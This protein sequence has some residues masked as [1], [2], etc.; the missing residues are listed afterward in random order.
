MLTKEGVFG[1]YECLRK[2]EPYRCGFFASA[3]SPSMLLAAGG[4]CKGCAFRHQPIRLILLW[5]GGKEEP[6]RAETR[7]RSEKMDAITM[8][9]IADLFSEA[10]V[11]Q[12]ESL[13]F[14]FSGRGGSK[15]RFP[16][17]ISTR[18]PTG[19]HI[20]SWTRGSKRKIGSSS[21]WRN[22]SFIQPSQPLGSKAQTPAPEAESR[23]P[24]CRAPHRLFRITG[25]PSDNGLYQLILI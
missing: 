5:P 23:D 1:P 22:P 7:G 12:G 21:P 17:V 18:I 4:I 8:Q 16:F 11:K 14:R 10:L 20:D 24:V 9:T 15:P 3:N 2:A 6:S 25:V 19:L 13:S